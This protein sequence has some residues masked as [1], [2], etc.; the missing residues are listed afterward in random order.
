MRNGRFEA[1]WRI[2]DLLLRRRPAPAPPALPRH[3][4]WVWDGTPLEG[5]PVLVRCYHGLGDT[6][7]FIRYAPRLREIASRVIVWCQPSLL[8]LLQH[9][10]GVDELLPLHDGAVD[11]DYEVDVEVMELPF[12][13]RTSVHSIPAS[14][15]YITI[16]GLDERRWRDVPATIDAGLVWRAGDWGPQRSLAFRQLAP[17]FDL[18]VNWHILQSGPGLAEWQ[19]GMGRLAHAHDPLTTARAMRDLDLVISVDSMP[20]HLAGA[21]AVP[22]WTL[23]PADADWRWMRTR[24]DSPWYPTMRL[25][26]QTR[27]GDWAGV[28]RRVTEELRRLSRSPAAVA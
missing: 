22:V 27:P 20:A 26:R 19:P 11:A 5:R 3:H 9:V 8:P 21:L 15:P 13:F 18:P 17:L 25:F 2:S 4:Q 7:Q 16:P 6:I 23:L 24:T 14:V 1:A 10:D 12:V 28:V